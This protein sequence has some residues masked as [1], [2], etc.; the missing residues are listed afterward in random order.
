MVKGLTVLGGMDFADSQYQD[1]NNAKSIPAWVRFDAGLRYAMS[2][3]ETDVIV[4]FNVENLFD[5]NYWASVDRGNLYI[6]APRTFMLSS[7]FNF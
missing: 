2:V 4:R 6:G 1:L 7:T 5:N 3:R